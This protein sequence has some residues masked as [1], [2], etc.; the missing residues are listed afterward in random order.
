MSTQMPKRPTNRQDFNIGII[1]ALG[2]E[3]DMV[4]MIFD[5]RWDKDYERTP[6]DRNA[7]STGVIAGRNVVLTYC[8]GMGSNSSAQVATSLMSS[9]TGIKVILLVGICGVVPSYRQEGKRDIWLGDCVISTGVVQFDF[10]RKGPN[11]FVPKDGSDGLEH[12]VE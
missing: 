7:Y 12:T 10:G 6:N 3:A 1:C 5:K 4:E 9:F 8:P 11:S 2:L